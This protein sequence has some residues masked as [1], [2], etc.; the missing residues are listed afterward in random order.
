M[1]PTESRMATDRVSI[2][3]ELVESLVVPAFLQTSGTDKRVTDDDRS[4]QM[5]AV[6]CWPA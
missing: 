2:S 3:Y 4:I 5:P 1:T 6:R